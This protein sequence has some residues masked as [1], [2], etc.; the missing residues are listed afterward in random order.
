MNILL[1]KNHGSN[2]MKKFKKH[3]NSIELQVIKEFQNGCSISANKIILFYSNRIKAAIKASYSTNNLGGYIGEDDLLQEA[4]MHFIDAAKCFIVEIKG[5]GKSNV[6]HFF[7]FCIKKTNWRLLDYVRLLSRRHRL[8]KEEFIST[9]IEDNG[10]TEFMPDV[11]FENSIEKALNNL[12][13][14]DRIICKELMNTEIISDKTLKEIGL[15][16]T[17]CLS[18][19]R[20]FKK[21]L[22]LSNTQNV[23]GEQ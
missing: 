2:K 10:H 8:A 14:R 3:F 19:F 9:Y 21:E 15:H 18:I 23:V 17:S 6:E 1:S 13:K 4:Y 16:K 11:M 12:S 5:D 7:N 20:N 22:M